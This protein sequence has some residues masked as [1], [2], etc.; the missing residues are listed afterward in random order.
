[1]MESIFDHVIGVAVTGILGYIAYFVKN[2][3]IPV[4]KSKSDSESLSY[5]QTWAE[6][7]IRASEV[8]MRGEGRGKEKHRAVIQF[9]RE[10]GFSTYNEGQL[11]AVITAKVDELNQSGW[12]ATKRRK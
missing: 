3:V 7:A 5:L 11:G 4:L 10:Q 1:M 9:L 12:Q 6:V 2:N 8:H